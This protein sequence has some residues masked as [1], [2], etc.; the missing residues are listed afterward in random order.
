MAK[1]KVPV[2]ATGG[3]LIQV[4]RLYNDYSMGQAGKKTDYM[5]S[6]M[7]VVAGQ[8]FNVGTFIGYW[9]PMFLGVGVSAI[10]SKA[11]LN[12]YMAKVPFLN[13]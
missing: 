1:K 7:G 5:L 10:A 2:F 4:G 12:K 11:G 3:T 9:T 8:K 6:K 13:F